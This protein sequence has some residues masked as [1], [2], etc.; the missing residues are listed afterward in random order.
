MQDLDPE[1]QRRVNRIQPKTFDILTPRV[2]KV[3]KEIA[4]DFLIGQPGQTNELFPKRVMK[5]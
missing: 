2:R 4:F 5:L 1:V 3:Y